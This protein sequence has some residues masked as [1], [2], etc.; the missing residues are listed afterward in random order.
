[1]KLP[2]EYTDRLLQVRGAGDAEF[3]EIGDV[4][5]E[6]THADMKREDVRLLHNS[7]ADVAGVTP[8]IVSEYKSNAIYYPKKIR[9]EYPAL[10]RWHFRHAKAAGTLAS[11]VAWLDKAIKSADDY[12]G[13]PMPVRVLFEQMRGADVNVGKSLAHDI[14]VIMSKISKMCEQ[15]DLDSLI[16]SGLESA[17]E[18]LRKAREAAIES[19]HIK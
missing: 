7:I 11:S 1:M 8:D 16:K 2:Q 18:D 14:D 13:S 5:K 15:K 10:T 4:A 12:G 6:L 19:E 17:F 3:W 9:D